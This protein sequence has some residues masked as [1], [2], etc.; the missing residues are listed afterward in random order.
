MALWKDAASSRRDSALAVP[1]VTPREE[2]APLPTRSSSWD[3]GQRAVEGKESLIGPHLAIEG[4][5]QGAGHVRI[6]GRFTGDVTVDGNLTIEPGALVNGGVTAKAVTIAGELHGNVLQAASVELLA[7]GVLVGD[8]HAGSFVVA[9]GAR[10]RGRV[11]FG[12][13][14]ED[15]SEANGSTAL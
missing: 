14:G 13:R 12:W 3:N 7:T 5:I 11:E 6:A 4:K 8:V 9:A 10:M 1:D 15:G 2:P